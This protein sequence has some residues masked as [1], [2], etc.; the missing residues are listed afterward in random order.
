MWP[1]V[2]FSV[3]KN[4]TAPPSPESEDFPAP[5]QLAVN[6]VSHAIP[7]SPYAKVNRS[8]AVS[9][10]SDE[11]VA[12]KREFDGDE[13]TYPDIMPLPPSLRRKE[14]S[15]SPIIP[16]SPDPFSRFSSDSQAAGL[17]TSNERDPESQ[18]SRL[19]YSSFEIP[20]ERTVSLNQ[21]AKNG[22]ESQSSFRQPPSS[23]FSIDSDEPHGKNTLLPRSESRANGASLNPVK[24]IRKL[25]RKT[26]KASIS[27]ASSPSTSPIPPTP[28]TPL[29][30]GRST[31]VAPSPQPTQ[32]VVTNAMIPPRTSLAPYPEQTYMTTS[33]A[34]QRA[35]EEASMSFVTFDQ[36]SPYPVRRSPSL[37]PS[38]ASVRT[39][40]T[41]TAAHRTQF[42]VS[43]SSSIP[44]PSMSGERESGSARKSILKSWKK[45][46]PNSLSKAPGS[47]IGNGSSSDGRTSTESLT[48]VRKR[49]PSVIEFVSGNRSS[50]G[51][52]STLSEIPPSPVLPEQYIAANAAATRTSKHFHTRMQS[53][54]DANGKRSTGT[55]S[56]ES[57]A[58]SS[59][60]ASPP[61]TVSRDRL[62]PEISRGSQEDE[63]FEIIDPQ[64]A[65]HG[66]APSLSYSYH[67]LDHQA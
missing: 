46:P 41:T 66:K 34:A 19:H 12:R 25:W 30:S 7:V 43:S 32:E 9:N 2:P 59:L 64:K 15:N 57:S 50:M 31:P 3:L 21:N 51:A 54:V 37:Q 38:N 52:G 65:V 49:R 23:R 24:S 47:L 39:S 5:P 56:F 11:S 62:G 40:T 10:V 18:E 13:T 1:A 67:E 48:P 35:R 4:D 44:P 6:G 17:V 61:R 26:N 16:L 36:E 14:D 29:A 8:S 53:V 27:T 45:S 55:S 20:P 60:L 33:Q 58:S 42:S 28:T 22:S 63:R